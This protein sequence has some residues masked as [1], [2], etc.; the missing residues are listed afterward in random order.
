MVVLGICPSIRVLSLFPEDPFVFWP[1]FFL[2]VN[3]VF[4][5]RPFPG[6][7]F[8]NLIQAALIVPPNR[9]PYHFAQSA[10][11][12]SPWLSLSS[13]ST[14][15]RSAYSPALGAINELLSA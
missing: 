11:G 2:A 3:F 9:L 4:L 14:Y 13:Q 6:A 5:P 12:K 1:F 10:S 8:P 15:D 7:S